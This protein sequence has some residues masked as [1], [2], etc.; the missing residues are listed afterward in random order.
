MGHASRNDTCLFSQRLGGHLPHDAFPPNLSF[1]MLSGLLHGLPPV[2]SSVDR[3]PSIP[4]FGTT[5]EGIAHFTG[6]SCLTA[7]IC[8]RHL[9][10]D[11]NNSRWAGTYR[12]LVFLWFDLD[13][14]VMESSSTFTGS[15]SPS[16]MC[17]LPWQYFKKFWA[18]VCPSA[19]M[20]SFAACVIESFIADVALRCESLSTF[21]IAHEEFLMGSW[22]LSSNHVPLKAAVR[23]G[24]SMLRV[25]GWLLA[26]YAI[27][28]ATSISLSFSQRSSVAIRARMEVL[29]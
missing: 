24:L 29:L 19:D 21:A 13:L 10:D 16:F 28:A 3:S 6:W 1:L 17:N 14:T 9:M 15:S 20:P 7:L 11:D 22:P 23:F 2:R 27:L 26:I 5:R 18:R 12:L 25:L 4:G 8:S